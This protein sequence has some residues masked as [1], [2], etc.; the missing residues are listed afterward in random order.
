MDALRR[1]IVRGIARGVIGGGLLAAF[2][3]LR[4]ERLGSAFSIGLLG[5]PLCLVEGW[6]A[7]RTPP[8]TR[9]A[10]VLVLCAWPVAF[11]GIVLA[12][13]QAVY[14]SGALAEGDLGGGVGALHAELV[15]AA[16]FPVRDLLGE[17]HLRHVHWQSLT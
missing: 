6:A 3:V 16:V 7:R 15:L 4:S 11:V 8:I 10:A 9:S 13:L 5:A 14:A 17:F 12:H 2:A 1:D